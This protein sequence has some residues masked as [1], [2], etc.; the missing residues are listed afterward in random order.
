MNFMLDPAAQELIASEGFR[1]AVEGT[2]IPADLAPVIAAKAL[3]TTTPGK[4]QGFLDLATEI[5]K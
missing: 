2:P 5:Y 3:G 4:T 1:P